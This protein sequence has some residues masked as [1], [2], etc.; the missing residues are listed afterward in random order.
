MGGTS[1]SVKVKTLM[2]ILKNFMSLSQKRNAIR[3]G[4]VYEL[5]NAQDT[6]LCCSA[7]T[8]FLQEQKKDI[9]IIII[10]TFRAEIR[11]EE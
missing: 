3:K 11:R 2:T 4:L 10:I 9:I 6:V 8:L 1:G 7:P 5:L